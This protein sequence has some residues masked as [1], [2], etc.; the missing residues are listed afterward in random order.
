VT[1]ALADLLEKVNREGLVFERLQLIAVAKDD[2][3]IENGFL[4]PT[5]KI[6][7]NVLDDTYGPQ[8]DSWYRSGEKVIWES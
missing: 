3:L 6:K 2:W 8:L 1:R 7:R 5:M 4:T